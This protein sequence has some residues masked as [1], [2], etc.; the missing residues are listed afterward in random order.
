M[1]RYQKITASV[2]VAA[3]LIGLT[4]CG[5]GGAS[6]GK[7]TQEHLSAA[8][9]KL[10]IM[11]SA[12]EYDMARQ[13]FLAGDLDKALERIERSLSLN[14]EV[15]KSNV[16][17]GRILNEMGEVDQSIAA[18]TRAVTLDAS[19]VEAQYYM[20]IVYERIV[21]REKAAEHFIKAH[22][23]DPTDPQYLIA[24]V[25]QLMDM[26]QIERAQSFIESTGDRFQHNGGVRQTLGHLAM[27][28]GEHSLAVEMFNQ[29]RLLTPDDKGIIEDLASAQIATGQVAAAESNLAKL[30][31]DKDYATRRDLQH[32]R[33]R[34]LVELNRLVEA[35]TAYLE[36]TKGSQG[37]SDTEA[38]VALGSV[39]M[40]LNDQLRIR[41]CA[42]RV[43]ALLP[44]RPEGY[45][46]RAAW[47]RSQTNPE[48]A[49]R[50]LDMAQQR[51]GDQIVIHQ[52]R[53]I[54]LKQLGRDAEARQE[55]LSAARADPTNPRLRE[56][57]QSLGSYANVPV[58]D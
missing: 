24:A 11:K 29:A 57:A 54:V 50:W 53:A 35:R 12:T 55:I 49:L 4:G 16:L 45:L 32:T 46:Y 27:I 6:R 34:A 14:P 37:S 20:G 9:V 8:R 51:G 17:H 19:N 18:F 1:D 30:L 26:G 56:L 33:A 31:S 39:A 36:L 5:G 28:R 38:W 42:Q 58:N 22:E 43:V 48:P 25:E 7:Y 21:N 10:D 13:S 41:E 44:D 3:G 2:L 52:M 15:T 47:F 40:A 23:L